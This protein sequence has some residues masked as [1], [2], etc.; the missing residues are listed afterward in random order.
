MMATPLKPKFTVATTRE[1]CLESFQ[2][3]VRN[4]LSRLA[5]IIGLD[6]FDRDELSDLAFSDRVLGHWGQLLEEA[7]AQDGPAVPEP[8]WNRHTKAATRDCANAWGKI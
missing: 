8:I 5:N 6:P 3:A 7:R 2:I 1:V 4:N